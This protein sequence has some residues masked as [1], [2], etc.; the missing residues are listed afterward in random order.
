MFNM[1]NILLLSLCILFV[2]ATSYAQKQSNTTEIK[3]VEVSKKKAT[4][5]KAAKRVV[6]APV[7]RKAE[8][9]S[10]RKEEA[11]KKEEE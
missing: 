11:I 8:V 5:L 3:K 6:K 4:K 1:K 10:I 2:T 9:K 7:H